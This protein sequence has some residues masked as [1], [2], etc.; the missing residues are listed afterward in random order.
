[1]VADGVVEDAV[2][3]DETAVVVVVVIREAVIHH[4]AERDL[5]VSIDGCGRWRW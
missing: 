1:M 2:V 5:A 3:A 4:V